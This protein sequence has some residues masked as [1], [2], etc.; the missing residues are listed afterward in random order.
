MTKAG[1]QN[2]KSALLE[3]THPQPDAELIAA[4]RGGDERALEMLFA[5]HLQPVFAFAVRYLNNRSDAEDVTQE[6]FVKAWRALKKSALHPFGGFNPEKG[7]FKTWLLRIAKNTCID[8][9]RKR[10]ATPLSEL[11]AEEEDLS[12]SETCIDPAPLPEELLKKSETAELL[13]EAL[14]RMPPPHRLVLLLRYNDH[15][16]FREI[17]EILGE[18]LHTVKSRHRRA[19]AK[20]ARILLRA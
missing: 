11:T 19:L 3:G 4:H 2:S 8:V 5:R 1:K 20:L 18:P 14:E 16:A 6:T 17:A 7:R 10:R 9:L 12:L 13:A 15:C